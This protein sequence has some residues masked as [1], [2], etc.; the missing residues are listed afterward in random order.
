M[1]SRAPRIP[2]SIVLLCLVAVIGYVRLD[3]AGL[4]PRPDRARNQSTL[5]LVSLDGWRWDYH[6]LAPT[7]ALHALMARG[8]RADA[9]TPVFPTK[10]FPNHYSIVTGLYTEH[11]GIVGNSMREPGT[12]LR[13]SLSNRDAVGDGR[14]WQGEPIWATAQRQ[15]RRATAL[16]WPGSEAPIGGVRPDE[17]TPYDGSIPN[18]ERVVRILRWLDLPPERRP[19]FIT[20]YFSDADDAGHTYGPDSP[21]VRDAIVALDATIGE[22]VR[23]ID[24]RGLTDRVN[25]VLVSD[26]GMAPI[27]PK[28][29]IV[30][31]DYVSPDEVELSEL[32]PNLA[33]GPRPGGP[34]TLDALYARLARAHPR[35]R[36]YRRETAPE[37][38]RYRSSPRVPAVVGIADEGWSIAA[39]AARVGQAA[40]DRGNHGF[41]ANVRS[42]RG[43]FIAAGPAFRQGVAVPAFENVHVYNAL[44][45]AIGITPAKNDGDPAVAEQ[46]L[47]K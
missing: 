34:L 43:I 36:V 4:W 45:S 28:Q 32:N 31:S 10:T 13:F 27:S 17:W 41:D 19:A 21:E 42:M 47:A 14:W 8:V 29:V 1:G 24:A 5:I 7:P 30:L 15:G 35:L 38:W 16:F 37:R 20:S 18:H 33:I 23:G 26:H 44:A 22:L 39:D 40:K 46:L 3:G 6:T 9:L 25:L 12:T 11:H 2:R